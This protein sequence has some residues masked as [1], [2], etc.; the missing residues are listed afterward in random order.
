M[1]FQDSK[2]YREYH[3]SI[4]MDTK[5]AT[6]YLSIPVSN[7][8]VDYEEYYAIRSDWANRPDLHIEE[9]RQFAEQCRAHKMD[10]RILQ[11]P[12]SNRGTPV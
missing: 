11:Q 5:T 8:F 2:S 1:R 12:G 4:G 9:L 3:F 7:G 6:P 10:D